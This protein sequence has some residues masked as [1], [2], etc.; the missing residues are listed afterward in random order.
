M[1]H[2]FNSNNVF[3]ENFLSFKRLRFETELKIK[4]NKLTIKPQMLSFKLLKS[5]SN[6]NILKNYYFEKKTTHIHTHGHEKSL[7]FCM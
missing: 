5:N 7:K 6:L 1:F 3:T 2:V 4:T